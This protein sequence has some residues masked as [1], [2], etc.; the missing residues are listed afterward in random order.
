M[1]RRRVA[2]NEAGRTIASR[3]RAYRILADLTLD[4]VGTAM[5]LSWVQIRHYE[6]GASRV[7]A[8]RLV[9]LAKTLRVS[10]LDLLGIGDTNEVAELVEQISESGAGTLLRHYKT[11]KS[12]LE[13]SRLIERAYAL[14]KMEV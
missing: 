1:P 13:R 9:L 14:A 10:V 11:I 8:D 7:P 12:P 2:D 5:D 3:I 6:T 4:D